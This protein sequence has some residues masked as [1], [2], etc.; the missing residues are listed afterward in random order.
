MASEMKA[1]QYSPFN[2]HLHPGFWSVFSKLKLEV[3]G[4][5][6]DPVTMTGQFVN[7]G[8]KNLPTSM[9]VEWNAFQ[10]N[11]KLPWNTFKSIGTLINKNTLDAFKQCDKGSIME[12]EA[13]K[14]QEAFYSGE[15]LKNPDVLNRF[16]ILMYADLKKYVFY[17]WFA[18]PAVTLPD[19]V[20]LAKEP[21]QLSSKYS[22]AACDSLS[23]KYSDLKEQHPSQ[24]SF[25][26]AV[27]SDD[28]TVLVTLKEA[29]TIRE[30]AVL[31][32][33]DPSTMESNPGW[34]LRN[35]L[36]LSFYV[37]PGKSF[38]VICIRQTVVAGGKTNAGSSL[39][40]E[41]I[42]PKDIK[43]NGNLSK[44]LKRSVL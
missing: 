25:F 32:F 20:F 22:P 31:C 6:E 37:R 30:D 35:L 14:L 19:E 27:I 33:A 26:G 5:K 11:V 36:A 9:N 8:A 12:V 38:R 40:L 23:A 10:D 29:L 24:A 41:V 2:S 28:S 21:A 17:Y 1:L 4:L 34:P 44:L 39:V 18:F 7:N 42:A 15:A 3:L 43:F 16:V 13:G